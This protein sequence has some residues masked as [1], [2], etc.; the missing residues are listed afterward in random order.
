M[1]IGVNVD[2]CKANLYGIY[3]RIATESYENE[4]PAMKHM[5]HVNPSVK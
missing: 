4:E 2:T 1:S 5:N 3:P